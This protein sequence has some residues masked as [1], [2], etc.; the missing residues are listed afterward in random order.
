MVTK[1][2]VIYA[3]YEAAHELENKY[4]QPEG[5]KFEFTL[6]KILIAEPKG[7]VS[8]EDI[9]EIE[10]GILR[11]LY[12]KINLSEGEKV[13]I[14]RKLGQIFGYNLILTKEVN[15][16]ESEIEEKNVDTVSWWIKRAIE[17]GSMGN[18]FFKKDNNH[19][20]TSEE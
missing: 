17:L 8:A 1:E 18:N 4:F 7:K 15:F 5:K 14:T 11:I 20:K 13:H 9:P 10:K 3:L 12:E 19:G 6:S 2:E 16:T